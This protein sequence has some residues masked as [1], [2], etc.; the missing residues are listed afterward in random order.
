MKRISFAAALAA[1][2]M[3]IGTNAFANACENHTSHQERLNAIPAHLLTAVARAESGKYDEATGKVSAWPWTVTSPEGD[4]KYAS[5]FEAI[6]AVRD[7]Q[8]KGV[9]NIDVGCMQI[10]LH[11][12]PNAFRNL[13]VAFDPAQNVAYAARLLRGHYRQTGDWKM[14]VAHYHSTTPEHYEPYL[15]KVEDLLQQ[16]QADAAYVSWVDDTDGLDADRTTWDIAQTWPDAP[17]TPNR[18]TGNFNHNHLT[19]QTWRDW[20]NWRVWRSRTDTPDRPWHRRWFARYGTPVD[21]DDPDYRIL[22]IDMGNPWVP[23]GTNRFN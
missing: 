23:V 9:H 18:W 1:L 4:V 22:P 15:A 12:H 2:T 16:A 17:T 20:R 10:N 5:K 21:S 8:R 3:V 6:S 7:L 14:A 11:H 13:N 19:W